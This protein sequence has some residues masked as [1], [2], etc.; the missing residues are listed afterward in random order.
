[1]QLSFFLLDSIYFKYF[2]HSPQRLKLLS[3]KRLVGKQ[4]DK[5][6]TALGGN[7]NSTATLY[8]DQSIQ[9]RYGSNDTWPLSYS[10]LTPRWWNWYWNGV[11]DILP[12]ETNQERKEFWEKML[13]E[14][15]KHH[16]PGE[17]AKT[18]DESSPLK[19][20]FIVSA[21]VRRCNEDREAWMKGLFL[22]RACLLWD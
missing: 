13:L 12:S 1:V 10:L 21:L 16:R 22:Y 7:R 2:M 15:E 17:N 19:G 5:S 9:F 20:P 4:S 18:T 8:R 11:S 14:F 6:I 3:E